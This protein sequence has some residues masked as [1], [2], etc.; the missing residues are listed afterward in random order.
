M[1]KAGSL[2]LTL[3]ILIP[4]TLWGETEGNLPGDMAGEIGT[5]AGK[6]AFIRDKN[7]WV[8]DW[9]GKNQFKV[10]T[11]ENALGKLSWAPD[12]K[13]IA[14]VREGMVD[15]K[16]PDNLG[17]RH[18]IYDIFLGYPDSAKSTTNW[19]FRLT[20]EYGSRYPEFSRDGSRIVFTKDLNAN[21]V[22]A[23]MPNYQTCFMDPSG[24]SFEILRKD[25]N[26]NSEYMATMP[27]LG[28]NGKYA[29]VLFQQVNTVG[30]VI[31]PLSLKVFT[32]QTLR[33][34]TKVIVDATAPAWSPDGKWL[35]YINK[36]MSDQ[37]IFIT[38][39]E[40]KHN[41]TVFKPQIGQ[42][43]QTYPL[44]WS[45]D[46]KWIVFALND[47]SFWITDITGNGLRQISGPGMNSAP[48]WSK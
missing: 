24:G 19:W 26:T 34:S 21:T 27:T 9:D 5:P 4:L 8:M 18:K 16:G 2:I 13:S 39:P 15:V 30:V 20:D 1:R 3:F 45:P 47:G 25:Y 41:Y 10:V 36:S 12:G 42:A 44:S 28:T 17:G 40:L 7:L 46:S 35:A 11:A 31:A 23:S 38:D 43:L 6:I 29:F 32:E 22:N 37:G 14:F 48:A 33:D